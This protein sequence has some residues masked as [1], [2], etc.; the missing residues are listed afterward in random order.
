MKGA[1]QGQPVGVVD[2]HVSTHAPVKGATMFGLRTYPVKTVSTHAPVKGATRHDRG[3]ATRRRVSTHAP[4]K[5]ATDM[6]RTE[7]LSQ[8]FQ[9]TPP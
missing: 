3:A 4:V 2:V 7:F 6:V 8:M 1:T 5:G 9:P